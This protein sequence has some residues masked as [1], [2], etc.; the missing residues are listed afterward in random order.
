MHFFFFFI[1]MEIFSYFQFTKGPFCCLFD[2]LH[3]LN[4]YSKLF[5]FEVFISLN[6]GNR[7]LQ[8]FCIRSLSIDT[9]STTSMRHFIQQNE[10]GK[11]KKK[12]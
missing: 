2:M 5:G 12:K 8:P 3:L 6:K 11:K 7:C 10:F 9:V 1:E 4:A